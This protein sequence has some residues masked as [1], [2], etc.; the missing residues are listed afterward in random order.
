M[1]RRLGR[2]LAHPNVG[3]VIE[4]VELIDRAQKLEHAHGFG[5][6]DPGQGESDVNQNV[7]INRS[8][9]DVFEANPLED[10][11]E[12]DPA[13]PHVVLAIGLNDFAGYGEAHQQLPM[14]N[15]EFNGLVRAGFRRHCASRCRDRELAQAQ[16]P[17]T[18]WHPAVAMDAEACALEPG[19]HLCREQSVLKHAS[20]QDH[21]L[22]PRPLPQ[23]AAHL[24]HDLDQG[25]METPGDDRCR[26]PPPNARGHFNE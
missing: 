22:E 3:I 14:E 5:L 23:P 10:S 9:R 18:R 1:A 20:T 26:A 25:G 12:I 2:C 13:H 16:P 4:L 7:I 19:D 11:A 6:V 8:V 15:G 17:I 24:G 21:N